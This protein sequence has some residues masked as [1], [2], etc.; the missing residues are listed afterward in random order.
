[1]GYN[2]F[3]IELMFA[4]LPLALGRRFPKENLLIV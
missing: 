3:Q 1:M 4:L 2:A